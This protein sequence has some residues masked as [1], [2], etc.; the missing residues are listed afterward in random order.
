MLTN[1]D[2]SYTSRYAR[3]YCLLSSNIFFILFSSYKNI[4]PNFVKGNTPV[5]RYFTILYC[6]HIIDTLYVFCFYQ[7]RIET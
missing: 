5:W 7:K 1:A 2:Q 6:S 3:I 4:S